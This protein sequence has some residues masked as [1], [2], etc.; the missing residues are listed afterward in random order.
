VFEAGRVVLSAMLPV[1]PRMMREFPNARRA[2][3][4]VAAIGAS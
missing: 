1:L 4:R 2:D 3:R